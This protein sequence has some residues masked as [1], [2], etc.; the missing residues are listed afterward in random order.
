MTAN[1]EFDLQ[2]AH[3]FF[4]AGNFNA[5]WDLIENEN[6][7]DEQDREMLTLSYASLYHWTQRQDVK[8]TNLS[9]AYWQIS[10]IYA[11]LNQAE[12]ARRYGEI[13]LEKLDGQEGEPFLLGYAYEALARA[14]MVAGRTDVMLTYHAQAVNQLELIKDEEERKLLAADLETIK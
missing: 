3:K 11:L 5:A 13:S 12:N 9:V 10:R 6:R 8:D 1:P 2:A 14:A 7:S 4:S